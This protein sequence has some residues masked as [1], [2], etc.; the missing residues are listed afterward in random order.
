MPD[1]NDAAQDS[2][3][4]AWTATRPPPVPNPYLGAVDAARGLLVATRAAYRD[5]GIAVD[6]AHRLFR[7]SERAASQWETAQAPRVA[8]A[9]ANTGHGHVRARPDGM[10]ARCGGPG[11][12]MVCS[13]EAGGA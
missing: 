5:A 7:E 4:L 10:V 9:G 1:Q 11:V 2:P 8:A 13:F 3:G 12:C 6:E